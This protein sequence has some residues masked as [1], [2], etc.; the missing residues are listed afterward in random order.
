MVSVGY[1]GAVDDHSNEGIRLGDDHMPLSTEH[2]SPTTLEAAREAVSEQSMDKEGVSFIA[3]VDQGQDS[4]DVAEIASASDSLPTQLDIPIPVTADSDVLDPTHPADDGSQVAEATSGSDALHTTSEVSTPVTANTN[5]LDQPASS[6]ATLPTQLDVSMPASANED[7]IELTDRPLASP[8]SSLPS[9]VLNTS[10]IVSSHLL[11]PR[12]AGEPI[13]VSIPVHSSTLRAMTQ[14]NENLATGSPDNSTQVDGLFTPAEAVT[15]STEQELESRRILTEMAQ[16]V[17][18][19]GTSSALFSSTLEKSQDSGSTAAPSHGSRL[20]SLPEIPTSQ[21]LSR[22]PSATG[23]NEFSADVFGQVSSTDLP[24]GAVSD[25]VN[26][27]PLPDG[28]S[29]RYRAPSVSMRVT[30]SRKPTDPVLMADPYP[31]CL[32]T[33]G[34]SNYPGQDEASEEEIGFDNSQSSIS[35]VEKEMEDKDASSIVDD[36]E[37]LGF[38][39]PP[40]VALVSRQETAPAQLKEDETGTANLV[41]GWVYCFTLYSHRIDRLFK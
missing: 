3:E 33:P 4:E 23:D 5:V 26:N 29:L 17:F 20:A 9:D 19:T 35:T 27:T 22:L 8:P 34:P 11:T 10:G 40:D 24:E 7:V 13:P 16:Y 18:G 30:L 6:I 2:V 28:T 15:K 37:G 36:D 21:R 31:Y 14:L 38:Q 25:T 1:E 32:S 12:S 41:Q 39:Y